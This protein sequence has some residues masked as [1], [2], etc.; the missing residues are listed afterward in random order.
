MR[1]LPV[2][3]LHK[4][5]LLIGAG[6][7]AA[8]KA[9][10]ISDSDCK[11]TIIAREI[12]DA[13][14]DTQ[15]VTLKSFEESDLVSADFDIVV[16]ATGDKNLSKWLWENRKKYHYWL[17]C[18]DMPEFCDFYFEA[19]Y[20]N[21]DLCVSVSTGGASPSYAQHIRDLLRTCVPEQPPEFYQSLCTQRTNTL[22][23]LLPDK[24][25]I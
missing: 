15:S 12:N 6:K 7:I 24:M 19:T 17:N 1:I 4:H 3:V 16:N 2:A 20:R 13:T 18:V 23:Y 11:L 5:V 21:H 9:K 25:F 8:Q 10:V 14:F 22:T